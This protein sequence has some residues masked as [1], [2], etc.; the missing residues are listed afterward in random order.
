MNLKKNIF[1]LGTLISLCAC[2]GGGSG[3]SDKGGATTGNSNPN[4]GQQ[5]INDNVFSKNIWEAKNING[6]NHYILRVKIPQGPAK[7]LPGYTLFVDFNTEAPL[8][9]DG[10]VN[11]GRNGNLTSANT[12]V[13]DANETLTY[14]ET[15]QTVKVTGTPNDILRLPNGTIFTKK[16]P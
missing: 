10:V 2:S 6:I 5:G 8:G 13:T 7:P 11:V 14:D 1:I 3:G 4:S 12:I 15:Q 9:T 16:A